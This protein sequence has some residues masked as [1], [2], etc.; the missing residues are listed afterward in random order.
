MIMMHLKALITRILSRH[1]ST[2]TQRSWIKI[3]SRRS[4]RSFHLSGRRRAKLCPCAPRSKKPFLPS[5]CLLQLLDW[6]PSGVQ[7]GSC[8]LGDDEPTA[9]SQYFLGDIFTEVESEWTLQRGWARRPAFLI[10]HYSCLFLATLFVFFV[11]TENFFYFVLACTEKNLT[12]PLAV[13]LA[14]TFPQALWTCTV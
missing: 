4:S 7:G 14:N 10:A 12:V 2:V 9:V 5:L 8:R 1:L 3:N 6:Q 13:S 11:E